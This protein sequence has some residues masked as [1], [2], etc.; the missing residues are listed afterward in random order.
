MQVIYSSSPLAKA[1][2]VDTLGSIVRS[3]RPC[4]FPAGNPHYAASHIEN[5]NIFTALTL[6]HGNIR[7]IA[8]R[9]QNSLFGHPILDRG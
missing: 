6:D 1:G 9:H 7:L 5:N 3:I 8:E 4:R 2:L